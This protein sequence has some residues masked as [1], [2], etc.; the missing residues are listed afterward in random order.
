MPFLR[1]PKC[2][3]LLCIIETPLHFHPLKS[4]MHEKIKKTHCFALIMSFSTE[5]RQCLHHKSCKNSSVLPAEYN[6]ASKKA[7]S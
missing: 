5:A 1:M 6:T 3:S 2:L 4:N 7:T